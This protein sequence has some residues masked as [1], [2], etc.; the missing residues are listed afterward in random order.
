MRKGICALVPGAA[1]LLCAAPARGGQGY[2]GFSLGR[3]TAMDAP[4]RGVWPGSYLCDGAG[5]SCP[6][7]ARVDNTHF[8]GALFAGAEIGLVYLGG[9]HV[10]STQNS[11]ELAMAAYGVAIGRYPARGPITVFGKLGIGYVQNTGPDQKCLALCD[12][13]RSRSWGPVYGTGV[14]F[15]PT[16]GFALRLSYTTYKNVGDKHWQYTA[17]DF[18]YVGIGVVFGDVH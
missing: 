14:R 18:R 7:Y 1:V 15:A 4:S 11:D 13:H 10:T 9:Y 2:F 3:A 17:G 6:T 12:T 5:G 8:A 16:P